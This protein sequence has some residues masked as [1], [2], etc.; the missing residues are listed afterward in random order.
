MQCSSC[1]ATIPDNSKFCNECGERVPIAPPTVPKPAPVD[2]GGIES[3]AHE[4]H[5]PAERK[6]PVPLSREDR[7]KACVEKILQ[8]NDLPAFSHHVHN[9]VSLMGKDDSS[10]RR[11]TNIILSDYS[12]SVEVMRTANSMYYNRSGR[13]ICSVTHAIAMMGVDAIYHLA[14]SM[15]FLEHYLQKSDRLTE[16]LLLSSITASHT[17]HLAKKLF[18][19]R[20][21]EASLC[22]LLRN[23]GEVLIACYMPDE[24]AQI[25]AKMKQRNW[26]INE[27][28]LSVMG[29][30]YEEL[31]RAI[32]KQWKFPDSIL[33][34]M[35]ETRDTEKPT[36]LSFHTLI[37]FSHAL[38][39]AVYRAGPA[40]TPQRIRALFDKYKAAL[41]IDHRQASEILEAGIK[42]T[43]DMF[44]ALKV[45]IDSLR[46]EHQ[47]DLAL[48]RVKEDSKKEESKAV[49]QNLMAK[50]N[51]V[52]LIKQL[53]NEIES[54]LAVDP[55]SDV[56]QIILMSLE[57]IFRGGP[58]DRVLLCLVT[59]DRKVLRGRLGL[60]DEIDW[61]ANLVC[62]QLRDDREPLV[63][64]LLSG[65]DL[66]VTQD[67]MPPFL[68]SKIIRVLNPGCF[69]LF[70]IVAK[71]ILIGAIYFDR[72]DPGE[73]IVDETLQIISTLREITS[74][75]IERSRDIQRGL[76]AQAGIPSTQVSEII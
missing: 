34:V 41:H 19:S 25:L 32:A 50:Q 60:G 45:P 76:S 61:V 57:A 1:A 69:G 30:S 5:P 31:G 52:N 12:L 36:D 8:S 75:A 13:S 72:I 59:P 21:E 16:L 65:Q 3:R 33:E 23:L 56:S 27:A 51:P 29:F 54:T 26:V 7:V 44:T 40:S 71:D 62:V 2:N 18:S 68:G 58:F 66:F 22:G 38:T 39:N 53:A 70:P 35:D 48:E 67:M 20:S 14:S 9:L 10:L 37:S 11:L 55:H 17:R 15:R 42:D 46:L 63:K 24:Y 4:S 43:K 49:A 28:C 47:I 73:P 74:R 6:G 64:V